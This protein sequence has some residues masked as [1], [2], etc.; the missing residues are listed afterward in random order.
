MKQIGRIEAAASIPFLA[1]LLATLC[2][3]L[4]GGAAAAPVGA[5]VA[6]RRLRALLRQGAVVVQGHAA[7]LQG[8]K[9]QLGV[10]K[11]RLLSSFLQEKEG[12]ITQGAN[13][14]RATS[15]PTQ[16]TQ[17]TEAAPPQR[18]P[19]CGPAPTG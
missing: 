7:S 8:L 9:C 19:L 4:C 6:A 16:P 3:R 13:A 10:G 12:S 17:P 5:G 1:A 15:Q 2:G 18:A 14:L 11:G